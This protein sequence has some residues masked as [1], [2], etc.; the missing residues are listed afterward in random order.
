M[1]LAYN[2]GVY[3]W[4]YCQPLI[5]QQRFAEIGN[6]LKSIIDIL[7]DLEFGH[8][9]KNLLFDLSV[10]HLK[11]LEHTYLIDTIQKCASTGGT[12]SL[13]ETLPAARASAGVYQIDS[14][15][16]CRR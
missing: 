12:K 11:S 9:D 3:A 6:A 7:M 14:A 2:G 8:M 5:D 1:V 16:Q 15:M 10:V 13:W 4:N